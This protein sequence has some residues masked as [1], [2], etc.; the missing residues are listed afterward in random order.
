MRADIRI[1]L[2]QAVFTG[3]APVTFGYG[4]TR[5]YG[6]MQREDSCEN[7]VRPE[8]RVVASKNRR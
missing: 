7:T 4:S 1:K 8:T 2:G 6:I 3:R 5:V